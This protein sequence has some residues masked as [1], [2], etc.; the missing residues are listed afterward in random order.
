MKKVL[1]W[2]KGHLLF[3]VCVLIVVIS[4]PV[5]F[6][7]S[8][9]W[10][11]SVKEDLQQRFDTDGRKVQGLD[12]TYGV[13]QFAPEAEA[14]TLNAPPN[15]RY[16]RW[17]A[18]EVARKTQEVEAVAAEAVA[19]NRRD[20]EPLIEGVFPRPADVRAEQVKPFEFMR[21][22]VGWAGRPG[23]LPGLI[24][25]VNGGMPPPAERIESRLRSARASLLADLERSRGVGD[26]TPAEQRQ[27]TEQLTERR[28]GQYQ[29]IARRLGVYLAP[30]TLATALD[31]PEEVPSQPPTL[32]AMFQTQWQLWVLEDLLDAVVLANT[33]DRGRRMHVEDAVVKHIESITFEPFDVQTVAQGDGFGG[34]TTGPGFATLGRWTGDLQSTDGLAP[35]NSQFSITGRSSSPSNTVYDVRR[36]RM[37]ALVDS[38]RVP[39]FLRSLGRTNFMSV[40]DMDVEAIDPWEAIQEG[41]SYGPQHVVRVEFLIETAWLRAWTV[42]LMP[43][44]V[45]SALGVPP[46]EED[47]GD[48]G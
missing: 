17:F 10:Q 5:A 13:P 19:F 28:I 35:R 42:P 30:E 43:E 24:E 34:E 8:S 14:V 12:V 39:V 31:L 4:L 22:L 23:V 7:L 29:Q 25:R 48:E 21:A 40:L 47:F 32:P 6:V 45:R 26:P 41:F 9:G 20:H 18:Q 3:V 16:T 37:T 38:A 36:V 2:I 46:D 1:G 15:E 27:I 11:S 33:D 44:R